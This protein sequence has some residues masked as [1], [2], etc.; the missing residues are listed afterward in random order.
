MSHLSLSLPPATAEL[1]TLRSSLR[2]FLED[3]DEPADDWLLIATE[4][5]TNAIAASPSEA[6]IGVNVN[7]E[8]QRVDLRVVDMGAG[9]DLQPTASVPISSARGRGLM[10]VDALADEFTVSIEDG[11]TIATASR[12][13]GNV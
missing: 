8:P 6:P 3:C 1:V 2:A 9:F 12:Q 7:V 4:L 13:R 10:M 5:V 11:R